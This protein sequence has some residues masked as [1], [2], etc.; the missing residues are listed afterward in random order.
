M[1]I[2]RR[3]FLETAPALPLALA[4]RS[5]SVDPWVELNAAHLRHN[6]AEVARLSKRPILAVIKNNGYGAGVVEVGRVLEPIAGVHGFAVVKIDEAFRLR[7]AGL[8]KPILLMG[9]YD[10][11]QVRDLGAR[12]IM[13]MV[14]RAPGEAFDDAAAVLGR[15][16]SVHVCV[17]TGLGRVGVPHR[18]AADFIRSLHRGS[19]TNPRSA[20]AVDGVMMTF[21][22]D[23]DFD[24]EQLAR[25]TSL[26]DGLRR[27]GIAL[28][29]R[30]AASS[31]TLFQG[32]RQPGGLAPFLLD[33]VRPGMA[34]FGVYPEA[35]FRSAGLLDLRPAVA[36]RA[37]IAY[38]KRILKGESA[39]YNRAY[40]AARDTWVATLPVGHADGL[41]RALAKGAKVRIG[42]ALYPVI[43]SVSASHAI[44][45]LGPAD[46]GGDPPAR[47]G[48]VATIF[49]WQD[50]SRPE[51]I[52][53]ACGASVYDLL[54]HLN[55]ALPRRVV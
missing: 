19:P 46:A 29:R 36:L 23:A 49:D 20:M 12:G 35:P 25:F 52:S 15:A 44:V 42:G 34:L 16:I 53:A 39:G 18:E 26:C 41:P 1:E 8:Q 38:V 50:G 6:V 45:E 7:D 3:A 9:P 4:A 33:M 14:Y 54:M 31:F 37:G 40:L 47:A 27:E 17:D 2:S 28:G 51:D 22:E 21:T 55:A 30:H 10:P 5:A 48:D 13:P 24:R 43:A 32:P 11:G